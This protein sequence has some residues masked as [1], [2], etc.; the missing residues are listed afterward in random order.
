[1]QRLFEDK[2]VVFSVAVLALLS[3]VLLAGALKNID[4]R[5]G[6]AIGRRSVSEFDE[7]I[8]LGELIVSAAEIPF[9]QQAFFW[10][11]LF[12]LVLLISSLL[13]PELRK[14]FILAFV[15]LA[16]FAMVFFFLVEKNP[17]LFSGLFSQLLLADELVG[18]QQAS[19]GSVP[20]FQPPQVSHWLSYAVALAMVLLGL[21][22][23]WWLN[24]LWVRIREMS[25]TREPLDELAAIARQSL[26]DLQ[27][28]RNFENAVLECYARMSSVVDKRKGLQRDHAMTPAEFAS[29]LTRAGLPREPVEKLTRLFEAVR[30]GRQ[31]AGPAEIN[32]AMTCLGSILRY[33]GEQP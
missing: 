24:R 30:Y 29:R 15:R 2:R 18:D 7:T 13:D 14:K 12:I 19:N 5:S 33:C 31:P 22:F 26:G 25:A 6:E 8:N 21:L 17:D 32:E 27:A 28:G 11:S 23:L 20:V 16:L 3:L 4:F 9:S 10:I 1:M